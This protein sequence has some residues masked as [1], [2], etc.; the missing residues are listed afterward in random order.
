[1]EWLRRETI[2]LQHTF[3]S[4]YV[5]RKRNAKKKLFVQTSI[6]LCEIIVC[7]QRQNRPS[8]PA[9]AGFKDSFENH[10]RLLQ[11]LIFIF[12]KRV[13]VPGWR[14]VIRVLYNI[15]YTQFNRYVI[16]WVVWKAQRK[17]TSVKRSTARWKYSL[18]HIV[19][20]SL[21]VNRV[22]QREQACVK[23]LHF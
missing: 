8:S 2:E 21:R 22:G 15:M 23:L 17:M 14:F 6:L 11:L 18:V 10:S 1:M 9:S 3:W 7:W 5:W 12:R 16:S 19:H 13:I 4:L 20:L